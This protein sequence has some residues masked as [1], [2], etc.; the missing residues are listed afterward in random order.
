MLQRACAVHCQPHSGSMFGRMHVLGL[1]DWGWH[2]NQQLGIGFKLFTP[3]GGSVRRGRCI[4][5]AGSQ[6][7]PTSLAR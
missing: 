6:S 1:A 4:W 3:S 5:P 7:W 2:G